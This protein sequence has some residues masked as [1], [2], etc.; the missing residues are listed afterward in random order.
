MPRYS[1]LTA[2]GPMIDHTASR[3]ISTTAIV[4]QPVKLPTSL[5]DFPQ[6]FRT[7]VDAKADSSTTSLYM[8]RRF[9][10]GDTNGLQIMR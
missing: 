6:K 5:P 4:P 7:S 3:E 8:H 2:V 1:S 10:V 9:C